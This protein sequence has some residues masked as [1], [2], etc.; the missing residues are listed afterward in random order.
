MSKLTPLEKRI[1]TLL[2]IGIGTG[3]FA[4]LFFVSLITGAMEWLK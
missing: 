3:I 2:G 4:V 1:Y